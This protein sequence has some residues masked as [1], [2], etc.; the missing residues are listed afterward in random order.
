[1]SDPASPPSAVP[2]SRVITTHPMLGVFGVLFGAM[3]ATCTGRL[4]SVGLADLRG[5]LHLGFDEASWIGTAFNA[6][7]MFIGPFSVY[8][9]GLLGARRV[10][11]A[12]ASLFTVVSL[13]LP[14][15][16]NLPI[17]L[18]LL[19]LA[20]LTAGTFYPLTLSFVL[21]NLPMRYVLIGIAT[22]AMD[23]VFTT[24]FATTL[25]AWYMD[26]LS[27]HWIFWSGA[28]LTPVMMVL[29]YFGIPWQP[30]PQP[31]EGQPK[32]NWRGFLYASLGLSLLYMALDQGQRLDWLHSGT[33][34]GLIV[35]GAFLI[36]VTVIRRLVMPNP[37]VNF[38]FLAR[39]NTLLLGIVLFFFRFIMLSTVVLIPSY[40]SSAKGYIALQT[41]PV[42][43]WVALPQILCGFLAMYLL[44]YVDA[45]LILTAGFAM[46]A[47]G[48]LVNAHLSSEWSGGNFWFSQAVLAMGFAFAFNGMVGAII[49][50]V[51]NTG[52]LSRPIDVLTFAGYFQ[53]VRLLGGE[54]GAAY[55][56]HFI[57]VREQF[58]SNILG[59]GVDLGRS[60]TDQRL[61]GLRAAMASHSPGLATATAR[62]AEILGLQVRQQAF[63]LAITDGFLLVASSVICCLLVIA[64]MQRVPTQYKQVISAPVVPA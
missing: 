1:M 53:T 40:L 59:L 31:K 10:L 26:H 57:P 52:A 19:V 39:R 3:I 22:Y 34:I 38:K 17:M 30:L 63:T 51:I 12:C 25:E 60:T 13:L 45:R 43:L 58:H 5:A 28:A 55:M 16:A 35:S 37:M 61:L 24:N 8:L 56:Q 18:A 29:I 33:I 47:M 49:L 7:L 27:W 4:I 62:A 41:G 15:A 23:I 11:L 44:Q 20:G 6:S 2:A 54:I 32:P 21:R 9:G 42:L 50:E 14:F 36:L 48:C 46:V 64:C